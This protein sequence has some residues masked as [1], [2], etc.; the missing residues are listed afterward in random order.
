M[1]FYRNKG[2]R[3]K[4]LN[5]QDTVF[6]I[7]FTLNEKSLLKES[8]GYF[9]SK[10]SVDLYRIGKAKCRFRFATMPDLSF[11]YSK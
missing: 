2:N 11:F 10:S 4:A 9:E 7:L 8:S 5:R 3:S 6:Q 1:G